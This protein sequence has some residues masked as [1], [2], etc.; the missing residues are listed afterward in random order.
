MPT[1]TVN[2]HEYIKRYCEQTCEHTNTIF[3]DRNTHIY[4]ITHAY[5][6]HTHNNI[7]S[8]MYMYIFFITTYIEKG[9]TFMGW[10][11][12]VRLIICIYNNELLSV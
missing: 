6:T 4:I 1:Q 7:L 5:S 11:E 2:K 12:I 9:I 3:R 10:G 8:H